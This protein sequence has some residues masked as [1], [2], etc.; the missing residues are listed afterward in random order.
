M[1]TTSFSER[2]FDDIFIEAVEPKPFGKVIECN[3]MSVKATGLK[4]QIGDLVN[5]EDNDGQL[6]VSAEVVAFVSDDLILL[7]FSSV[8]GIYPGA[9]V[10]YIGKNN[11]LK[12]S[13]HFLGNIIDPFGT[14]LKPGVEDINSV[15]IPLY[16]SPISP[17]ERESIDEQFETGIKAIDTFISMGVGQRMGVFAG[18]GVGKS[19]LLGMMCSNSSAD[20]NVVALIGE[21]GREVIDFVNHVI[22]SDI[23]SKTI[24]V[25]ASADQPALA[26]VRAAYT[27]TAI[28]EYYS[29]KNMSVM[30]AVDSLTR[31][32]TAQREIDIVSG[33]YPVTRGFTLSSLSQLPG[34]VERA[35]KFKGRGPIT[36]FYT[37]LVEGDEFDEPITDTLRAILDG[38]IL[39]SRKLASLNFFP[40]IDISQS[41]SRI[42][43]KILK[44]NEL[45]LSR[46]AR[47]L[48]ATYEESKDLIN[49][50]AYEKGRDQELDLSIKFKSKID[51]FLNQFPDEIFSSDESMSS[52]SNIISG[53][54]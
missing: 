38:H 14:P 4:A 31:L 48:L 9:R 37:V 12:Y 33:E 13:D 34:L 15:N 44:P 43:T 18:G 51:S 19:T 30:L 53:L 52:L 5:I 49:F 45:A 25:A 3:Q 10:R 11:T 16:R 21:R 6:L 47:S 50:G 27:A 41:I 7:P 42:Q 28:A 8:I 40:A 26:R 35:G 20:V 32:V 24:I 46:R 23:L 2:R 17:L 29:N 22:P 54:R 1:G 36:S 39:L